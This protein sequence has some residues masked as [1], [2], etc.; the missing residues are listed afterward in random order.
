ML[1]FF[2]SM[3]KVSCFISC[4]LSF[5]HNCRNPTLH[6]RSSL[7][8]KIHRTKRKQP[9]L[10]VTS[11][12]TDKFPLSADTHSAMHIYLKWGHAAW[13]VVFVSPPKSFWIFQGGTF[14]GWQSS[15][16]VIWPMPRAEGRARNSD[17]LQSRKEEAT[18]YPQFPHWS[19]GTVLL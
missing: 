14:W 1:L 10:E 11:S 17:R 19:W 9:H 15:E 3:S 12:D 13:G 6:I 16:V 4:S 7:N 2:P 5:L 18:P 8:K